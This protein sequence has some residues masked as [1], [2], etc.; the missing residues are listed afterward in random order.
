MH[1]TLASELQ[2][3]EEA[4]LRRKAEAEG[5]ESGVLCIRTRV[6]SGEMKSTAFDKSILLSTG[7]FT[8]F[9]DDR[10]FSQLATQRDSELAS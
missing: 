9:S 8:N 2:S 3:Q 5:L 4:S 6:P 10:S 7:T 1:P